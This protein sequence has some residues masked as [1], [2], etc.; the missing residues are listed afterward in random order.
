A[1]IVDIVMNHH[2]I[3]APNAVMYFD[4]EITADNPWFNISPPHSVLGFFFDLNHESDYTKSYLDSVNHYWMTEFKIDGFRFDLSK[5]FTQ[6]E[7]SGYGDWGAYDASRIAILKRMADEI[8]A[9]NPDEYI[10]LEHFA[11]NTEEKELSDYG[12]M[13]WGNM[14]H[15]YGQL[16]MGY[17]SESNISGVSASQRGWGENNLIG[18][19]ESHDEERLMYKC[20][21]FGNGNSSYSTTDYNTALERVMAVSSFFYTVPGPKMLWQFGETGFDYSINRCTNG[22]I[23]EN[24][25][26]SIKP[27]T[28]SYL[29]NVENQNLFR[30]TQ[31]LIALKTSY[32]IFQSSEV[33]FFG[34]SNLSRYFWLKQNDLDNPTNPNEMNAIVVGNF[35]IMQKNLDANFPHNGKWYHY[36]DQGDSLEVDGAQTLTLQPGEFRIYTDVRLDPTEPELYSNLKP[37]A[38]SELTVIDL[39]EGIQLNWTDNSS[40]N[41]GYK[42]YRSS[43]DSEY[44]LIAE[45]SDVVSYLDEN[46]RQGQEYNYYVSSFNQVGER[47][48]ESITIT[49]NNVLLSVAENRLVV[50]PNPANK[51]IHIS[52]NFNFDFFEILNLAGQSVLQGSFK[53]TIDVSVLVEGLYFINLSSNSKTKTLK[54]IKE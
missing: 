52:D 37:L 15:A 27:T 45:V 3:P 11:D 9:V 21:E 51:S 17:S 24:C 35:D 48:S 50:F 5:G 42:I 41:S 33:T 28:W 1:V 39:E 26:L 36:F 12:M 20:L 8:W 22:S 54:F 40:I 38:P 31:Q 2:D 13:L 18:Y 53:K 29:E 46:V 19:M 34:G 23:S 25:R 47:S 43:N 6:K 49:A 30:V 10:I 4:G 14:T 32:S 7:T 16:A 44:T